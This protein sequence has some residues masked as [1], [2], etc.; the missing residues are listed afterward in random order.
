MYK[1]QEI[2]KILN[3]NRDKY[4]DFVKK[5]VFAPEIKAE[6]YQ[7][8]QFTEGDLKKLKKIIL[9]TKLGLTCSDICKIQT[10]ELTLEDAISQRKTKIIADMKR[11]RN[12][13]T[14]AEEF[15]SGK[16]AYDTI[17]SDEFWEEIS[18]REAAG[19]EFIDMIEEDIISFERNLICP[20]CKQNNTYDLED[21]LYNESSVECPMGYDT[22]YYFDSEDT[23]TCQNC[24]KIIRISGWIREYPTGAY[25]S[26]EIEVIIINK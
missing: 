14:L 24:K 20:N 18:F 15:L 6:K 4:K 19:E 3:I 16:R 11:K 12:S 1:P 25:D 7:T 5:K 2:Y 26:E 13:L 23:C 8:Q 9:L 21:Y 17:D 10:N 22:T